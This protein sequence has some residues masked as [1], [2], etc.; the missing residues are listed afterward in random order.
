M[1]YRL[2]ST[3]WSKFEFEFGLTRAETRILQAQC[4]SCMD[5]LLSIHFHP[6]KRAHALLLK[7]TVFCFFSCTWAMAARGHLTVGFK[8]YYDNQLDGSE[9]PTQL[10]R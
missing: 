8:C 5:L 2:S 9:N 7:V 3:A 10:T 4:E 1:C 6:E